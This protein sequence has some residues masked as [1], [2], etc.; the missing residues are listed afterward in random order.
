MTMP[1]PP[2]IITNIIAEP[3]LPVNEVVDL[4]FLVGPPGAGA[5]GNGAA[6]EA[7][8][9]IATNVSAL[10]AFIGTDGVV[11]DAIVAITEQIT[12]RIA[13]A[14]TPSSPTPADSVAA[15]NKAMQ[16][17]AAPTLMYAPGQTILGAEVGLLSGTLTSAST[18]LSLAGAPDSA[19]AADSYLRISDEY[20]QIVSGSGTDYVVLRGVLGSAAADHNA[21]DVVHNFMSPVVQ[22]LGILT[23]ELTCKAVA[24]A[25]FESV[26]R[27]EAWSEAGNTINDVMAVF[28]RPDSMWVGGAWIGA[29]LALA[30][31]FNRARGIEFAP[32]GGVASLDHALSHSS[33]ASVPTD[34]SRLVAAYISTLV[35]RNGRIEI[36]GQQFRGVIDVR[37]YWSNSRMVDILERLMETE[38]ERFIGSGITRQSL[39]RIAE[40]ME[41]VGRTL[42]VSGEMADLTVVPHPTANTQAARANGEASF[43]VNA[44][45]LV[46]LGSVTLDLVLRI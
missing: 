37:R 8:S 23:T 7:P 34:V 26:E 44:T 36:I 10:E 2:L 16:L 45:T 32:V 27:A 21:T 15:L 39:L 33:R 5:T 24:D 43:V 29:I 25:P 41:R 19:F 17:S 40:A 3:I 42:V 12:T 31:R 1:T 18:A 28:N 35:S 4:V 30:T 22:R 9:A 13:V 6:D 11:H 20:M 38:A 46:P 14:L